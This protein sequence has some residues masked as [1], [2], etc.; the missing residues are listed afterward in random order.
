[1]IE[2]LVQYTTVDDDDQEVAIPHDLRY[3]VLGRHTKIVNVP[4]SNANWNLIAVFSNR[5]SAIKWAKSFKE[6]MNSRDDNRDEYDYKAVK[7]REP[8]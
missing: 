4:L 3:A 7:L 8:L 2:R 5:Y 1:M 6:E